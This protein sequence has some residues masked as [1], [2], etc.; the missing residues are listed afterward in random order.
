MG[1]AFRS[2]SSR[3]G[4]SGWGYPNDWLKSKPIL[5]RDRL[6]IFCCGVK[7]KAPQ[8]GFHAMLH[9]LSSMRCVGPD[10]RKIER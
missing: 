9:A 8:E 4:R 6:F 2:V 7:R 5:K 10:S 1:F 3:V